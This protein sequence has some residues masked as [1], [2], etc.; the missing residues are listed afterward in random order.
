MTPTVRNSKN[1]S[2]ITNVVSPVSLTARWRP[3][4]ASATFRRCR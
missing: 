1:P 3:R 4:A 2:G